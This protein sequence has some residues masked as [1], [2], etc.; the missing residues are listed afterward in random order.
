MSEQPEHPNAPRADSRGKRLESW[1]EVAGYLNRHVTTVRRWERHEK[2]PVH[3]HL[4]A[5]IGSIYAYTRELDAWFEHRRHEGDGLGL[6]AGPEVRRGPRPTP[7]WLTVSA[8]RAARL[9]GRDR[10]LDLLQHL[11]KE[12]RGGEQKTV[13]LS[14]EPGVGKTRLD[15]EFSRSVAPHATVL[16]GRCDREALV[17]YA[18]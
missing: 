14:G 10:E 8:T 11:W 9:V 13:F 3:R 15:L 18:P 6:P 1:K 12:A 5:K 16:L 7:P 17:A 2:L 4:H